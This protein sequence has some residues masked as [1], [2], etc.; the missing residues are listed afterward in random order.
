[1]TAWTFGRWPSARPAA[2][3]LVLATLALAAVAAAAFGPYVARGGLYWDDWE[4]AATTRH[5]PAGFVG[6][7]ELRL[8]AYRP[9]LAL[10]LP[11][12]HELAGT[13]AAAQLAI[14]VG[15][16]V[17]MVSCFYLLLRTAGLPALHAGPIALL[18]LLFPYSTATRLWPTGAINNVAV[19]LLLL[20]LCAGLRGLEARGRQA[21]RLRVAA[22]VLY[23]LAVLTYEAVAVPA[24][25]GS[26][27]LY[28]LRGG[29][30]AALRQWRWQAAS[31]VAATLLVVLATTREAQ[32]PAGALS[33]AAAI[34]GQA[35]TL[36][37]RALV[38]VGQPPVPAVLAGLLALFGLSAWLVRRLPADHPARTQT[39]LG[40]RL[41]GVG[42][43]AVAAGYAMFVPSSSQYEPLNG[44][45]G[46]RM[47]LVA[48]LG[49]ATAAWATA[50]T[51]G[52]LAGGAVGARAR[53][54]PG[55]LA[56]AVGTLV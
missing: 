7:V 24:L 12:P 22:A 4:N 18:T 28:A 29:W 35:T 44:G 8:L 47:N 34:A 52:G 38:P 33:H 46:D 11:L 49:F 42:A 45:T 20:G 31:I 39:A 25:V 26:L 32:S 21:T 36:L 16:V 5:P 17:A 19:A 23:V 48:A 10:L 53:W 51:V 3:E 54:A 43:L 37:G 50:L 30:P 13:H 2:G 55:A 9:V 56:A 40:V 27:G 1:M 15:L 6:P 41:L 14:A